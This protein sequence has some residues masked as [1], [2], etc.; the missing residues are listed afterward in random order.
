MKTTL[1]VKMTSKIRMPYRGK[2][3]GQLHS[4]GKKEG[5]EKADTT[6][7]LLGAR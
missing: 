2:S 5:E 4:L 6:H 3:G 1:K 7:V